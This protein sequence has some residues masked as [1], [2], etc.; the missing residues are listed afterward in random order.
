[1]TTAVESTYL[2]NQILLHTLSGSAFASPGSS[3]YLALF[4][5]ATAQDDDNSGTEVSGGDYERMLCSGSGWTTP[6]SG[7]VTNTFQVT[8]PRASAD[9][10]N[11]RYI[12]IMDAITSGNLLF[13]GQFTS[14]KSITEFDTFY[15]ESGD[16]DLTLG[17]EQS[18]YL[19][20]E[21]LNHIFKNT[22]YSTPGSSIWLTLYIDD[23]TAADVGTEVSLGVGYN[24]TNI[25]DWETPSSGSTSNS[26]SVI[27]G[28]TATGSWQTV[29]HMGLRDGDSGGNLLYYSALSGSKVVTTG[30]TFVFAAN[31]ISIERQ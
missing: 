26:N 1:M 29:T 30:D 7:S 22:E 15:I 9:W 28:S 12:G 23:P 21:L 5:D 27:V 2:S 8:Y 14:D 16:L 19:V 4:T 31:S 17:G 3:I 18:D 13:W 20:D 11:I 10:G 25:T 6:T 24:R